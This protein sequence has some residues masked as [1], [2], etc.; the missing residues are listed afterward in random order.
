MR[1]S[2]SDPETTVDMATLRAAIKQRCED[3]GLCDFDTVNA[4]V[5]LKRTAAEV[6]NMTMEY[7]KPVDLT[8]GRLNVLMVLNGADGNS[9]LLSDI[10]DYLVVSRPNVT[11]LIDGLVSEGL[12]KRVGHPQDR[13]MIFAQLTE[14]GK[15]F[16][17]RFAPFHFQIVNA[18]MSTLTKQEKRQLVILLDKLRIHIHQLELPQHGRASA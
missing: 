8:P 11:G 7:C 10:G 18:A 6:E 2:Q 12:V 14:Q 17:R 1:S 9:M 5:T 13:R 4:L 15:N 3:H 16:M